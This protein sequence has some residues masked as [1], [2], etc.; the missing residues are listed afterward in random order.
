MFLL[1]INLSWSVPRK[2]IIDVF[3]I[4]S[5]IKE[6]TP[7]LRC[8]LYKFICSIGENEVGLLL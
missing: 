4:D 2:Y 5:P 6:Y 7:V 1:L 3:G 8:T